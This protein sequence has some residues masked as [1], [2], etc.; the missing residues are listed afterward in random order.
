MRQGEKTMRRNRPIALA[1]L[2]CAALAAA[3]VAAAS[4]RR[5]QATT[6]AAATFAAGT[7]SNSH[8]SSCTAGDGTYEETTATYTGSA[9]SSVPQLNG[10][11]T[12]RAHSV[13]D[14][15]SGLGWVEGN[16][17][18]RGGDGSLHGTLNAALSGGNAVGTVV[19]GAGREHTR[20]V[21]TVASA[22]APAT[23]FTSGSLGSGSAAGAGV[24]YEHGACTKAKRV[25]PVEVTQL[26]FRPE[27]GTGTASGNLTLDVT[28]DSNGA[29][30]SANA[31]FYVN[32]RFGAPVT[33]TGLTL[34]EGDN[35]SSGPVVIDTGT[36]SFTDSDGSGNLTRT[37]ANISGSLAQAL[38]ENPRGY[39]VEL[40]TS[41]S[42]LRAQLGGF[43]RR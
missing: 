10:D 16:F 6:Q 3:G 22:F 31:V 2:G 19:S 21:A 5:T 7:V 33:I 13:L 38:L 14:T 39:Y 18:V 36:V 17:V 1:A 28:Q 11:L 42:A 40:T 15:T 25:R 24:L 41:S 8:T 4:H 37:V 43:G 20:L 32:Y 34:H 23:G 9:S 29:I 26:R 12:I 30:V 27:S 35:G